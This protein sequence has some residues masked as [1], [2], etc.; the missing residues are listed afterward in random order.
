M[1]WSCIASRTAASSSSGASPA[2]SDAGVG[3]TRQAG[4]RS[5]SSGHGRALRLR[6]RERT[7]DRRPGHAGLAPHLQNPD[8]PRA[9]V[10]ARSHART[11]PRR[12]G[13][14]RALRSPAHSERQFQTRPSAA[15]A[16]AAGTRT[17]HASMRVPPSKKAATTTHMRARRAARPGRARA[18][19]GWA[20]TA[21]GAEDVVMSAFIAGE[22]CIARARGTAHGDGAVPAAVRSRRACTDAD[23]AVPSLPSRPRLLAARRC[24]S[25]FCEGR[26]E[27]GSITA[28]LYDHPLGVEEVVRFLEAGEE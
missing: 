17:R 25:S 4:G 11:S 20:E 7:A 15:S 23:A 18:N 21:I 5:P 3:K 22:I 2:G 9:A 16:G 1:D 26:R 12:R 24:A 14:Y 28:G 13:R 10:V 8:E 27:A 19:L 6:C